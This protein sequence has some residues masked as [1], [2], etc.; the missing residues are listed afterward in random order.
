MH[1]LGQVGTKDT[2]IGR[3]V[4]PGPAPFYRGR[5]KAVWDATPLET[6]PHT[7]SAVSELVV[8]ALRTPTEA[9]VELVTLYVVV[10]DSSLSLGLPRLLADQL[11]WQRIRLTTVAPDITRDQVVDAV[12]HVL[13][14]DL[15]PDALA[16]VDGHV[17]VARE[18]AD[19]DAA[20]VHDEPQLGLRATTYLDHLLRGN[21][22][23]ALELVGKELAAGT[24]VG[25]ILLDIIQPAQI[26]LGWLWEQGRVSVA[27]EHFT[28]A[29]SQ[30]AMAM[31]YPALF[32]GRRNGRS[33]VALCAGTEAHEVGMR[34]VSDLLEHAGWR[35][36]YL[37]AGVPV[38]DV[39]EQLVETGADLL[40]VS[41]TMAGQVRHVRRLVEAVR[42]D[43]R[44]REVRI[45]V[46]GRPF[47]T[48]PG[49]AEAIGAD[50]WV[51][52]GSEAVEICDRLVGLAPSVATPAGAAVLSHPTGVA[53]A[54]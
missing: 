52:D 36:T 50:A 41:A 22:V 2:R 28:T 32:D 47:Q 30:L 4:P 24:D 45:V 37:G 31:L 29:V 40:A 1:G 10:L 18:L 17:A 44:L 27:Q 20:V 38:P 5:V 25:D 11:E 54:R 53:G 19:A 15:A 43:P 46:G 51:A 14:A 8:E 9:M 33:V 3:S 26:E 34:I 13:A 21:R 6:V 23:A 39:V 49:L 7:P 12:R 16:L 48:E 35:T 42:A